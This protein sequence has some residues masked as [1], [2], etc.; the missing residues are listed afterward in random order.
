MCYNLAL[1]LAEQLIC[2]ITSKYSVYILLKK[3]YFF[4]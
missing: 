1:R 4:L 3:V 2:F